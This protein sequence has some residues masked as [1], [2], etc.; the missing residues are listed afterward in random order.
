MGFDLGAIHAAQP[1]RIDAIKSDLKKRPLDWLKVASDATVT[2]VKN[3][4]KS[5]CKSYNAK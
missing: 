5:W 4:Y 1:K 2:N 3:D